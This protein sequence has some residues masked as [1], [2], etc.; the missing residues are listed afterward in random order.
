MTPLFRA[1]SPRVK[2]LNYDALEADIGCQTIDGLQVYEFQPLETLCVAEHDDSVS[3]ILS[4]EA[5][6]SYFAGPQ[7]APNPPPFLALWAAWSS[8]VGIR[9]GRY[10]SITL[11]SPGLGEASHLWEMTTTSHLSGAFNR[12]GY[13]AIAIQSAENTI[14]IRYF[15]D[16]EGNFLSSEWLGTS[17]LLWFIG[18]LFNGEDNEGREIVA[19]YLREDRPRNLYGRFERD[20]YADEKILIE[21]LPVSIQTLVHAETTREGQLLIYA[22]DIDGRDVR[23]YSNAYPVKGSDAGTLALDWFA[24]N[25]FETAVL[26]EVGPDKSTLGCEWVSGYVYTATVTVPALTASQNKATFGLEWFE[27]DHS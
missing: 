24:G 21:D 23:I 17:P 2:P 19:M 9:A 25:H 3:S 27:G 4:K 14:T 11:P 8:T 1:Y 7:P 13:M 5:K 22:R 16:A 18:T 12:D 10:S 20:G 15:V 26:Q 6:I